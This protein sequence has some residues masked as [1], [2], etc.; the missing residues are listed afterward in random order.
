MKGRRKSAGQL[1][2][3]AAALLAVWTAAGIDRAGAQDGPG[4]TS[5]VEVSS[6]GKQVYEEI[7]QACHMA[8]AKGGG[9]AGAMIPA[10]AA[11]PRLAEKNFSITLLLKGRA[12]MPWFT[13]ILTK[14]QMAAVLTYVRSEFNNYPEPVTVGDIDRVATSPE[15]KPIANAI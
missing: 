3:C 2:T 12:G 6:A 11:N 1:V 9:S 4:G 15:S 8:D 13:D 10:L 5:T 14:E 7:C